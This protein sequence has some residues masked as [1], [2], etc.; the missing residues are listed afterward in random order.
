MF[1]EEMSG[2]KSKYLWW[3]EKKHLI[4]FMVLN[5]GVKWILGKEQFVLEKRNRK[6]VNVLNNLIIVV[7]KL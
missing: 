2:K 6:Y 3:D 1:Q 7:T 4:L 5:S